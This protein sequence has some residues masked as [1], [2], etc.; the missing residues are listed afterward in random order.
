MPP[1]GTRELPALPPRRPRRAVGRAGPGSHRDVAEGYGDVRRLLL[2]SAGLSFGF[3][4]QRG[5]LD[6]PEAA[7][8]TATPTPPSPTTAEVVTPP[9]SMQATAAGSVAPAV[10]TPAPTPASTPPPT[11]TPT[12][13]PAPTP[14]ATATPAP[15]SAA[16]PAPTATPASDRYALLRPCPNRSDCWIYVVRSGDNLASIANYFGHSLDTIRAMNRQITNPT[17]IRA[18]D[19]IRMPPPTR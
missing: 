7:L 19:Q 1:G 10:A 5:G 13:T 8:A 9:P 3:V 4:L 12:A 17:T 16:T 2:A 18:G 6:L 15:T 14:A 11:P